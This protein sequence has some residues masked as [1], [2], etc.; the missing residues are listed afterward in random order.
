MGGERNRKTMKTEVLE[1]LSRKYRLLLLFGFFCWICVCEN[2]PDMLQ[3]LL[4]R[5]TLLQGPTA[6]AGCFR[7]EC[8][9]CLPQSILASALALEEWCFPPDIENLISVHALGLE[10]KAGHVRVMQC[11]QLAVSQPGL[12]ASVNPSCHSDLRCLW[13]EGSSHCCVIWSQLPAEPPA[14]PGCP[15]ANAAAWL[16]IG[17]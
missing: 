14:C 3:F 6:W 8:S 9:F 11:P 1:M 10:R 16:D 4:Q 17:S 5:L 12:K 13:A 15:L 2:S 7:D